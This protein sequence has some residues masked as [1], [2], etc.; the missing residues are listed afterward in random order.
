MIPQERTRKI[1]TLATG[2]IFPYFEKHLKAGRNSFTLVIVPAN[3][4][5]DGRAVHSIAAPS[6]NVVE[7]SEH[8]I[9]LS[10]DENRAS[11]W[12]QPNVPEELDSTLR[13]MIIGSE[14]QLDP[15]ADTGDSRHQ[16]RS[17][18]LLLRVKHHLA[19]PRPE[20]DPTGET[21]KW[22]IGWRSAPHQKSAIWIRTQDTSFRTENEMGSLDTTTKACIWINVNIGVQQSIQ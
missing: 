13:K 19:L 7:L 6:L 22:E 12:T 15:P 18:G 21:G 11:F 5:P 17:A 8:L 3:S 9:Q 20:H 10:G 4:L 1:Q 2:T 14:K 16:P